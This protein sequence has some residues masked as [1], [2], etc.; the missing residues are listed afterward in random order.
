MLDHIGR[1]C[2]GAVED[3]RKIHIQYLLPVL[4]SHFLQAGI[5]GDTRII[6]QHI[7][8]AELMNHIA[9]GMLY[10]IIFSRIDLAEFSRKSFMQKNQFQFFALHFTHIP[11]GYGSPLSCKF[12]YRSFTNAGS[13]TCD[14]DHSILKSIHR[15]KLGIF[16]I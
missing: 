3:S 11:Y 16:L 4:G 5:A 1:D 2:F 12:L 9:C 10:L 6:Y 13:T 15:T 8:P 7:Y 14:H